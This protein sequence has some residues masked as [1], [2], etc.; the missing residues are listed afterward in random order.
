MRSIKFFLISVLLFLFALGKSQISVQDFKSPPKQFYPQPFWHINGEM[1][2]T[3]IVRQLTDAK[4]KCGFQGVAVLPVTET[5]PEFLSE[6]YFARYRTI[7]KTAKKLDIKVILYDDITFP[8]GTA[9]KKMREKYPS[10][11][12]K[13]LSKKDTLINGGKTFQTALPKDLLMAA[14]AMNT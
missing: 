6:N 9:G 7:L 12:R 13:L 11:I 10:E 2:D 5:K 8:S 1:T 14:V 4:E 3:G